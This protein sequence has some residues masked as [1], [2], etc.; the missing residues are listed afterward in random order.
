MYLQRFGAIKQEQAQKNWTYWAVTSHNHYSEETYSFN[1]NRLPAIVK[2]PD[3]QQMPASE[4]K[5]PQLAVNDKKTHSKDHMPV[6]E[7]KRPPISINDT[8]NPTKEHIL[9]SEQ[10]KPPQP[11][12]YKNMPA[13]EKMSAKKQKG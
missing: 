7:Y 9:T 4:K 6:S 8:K 12:N 11:D 3:I 1:N 10:R 13:D 5:R 2:M